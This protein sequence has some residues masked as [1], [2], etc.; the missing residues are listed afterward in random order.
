MRDGSR[1]H[2]VV[3]AEEALSGRHRSWG[4]SA[5]VAVAALVGLGLMLDTIGRSSAT[6]DEPFYLETAARWWRTGDQ[7]EISRAGS[8]LTFWKL[9][10]IPMLWALD[11]L[12]R[13]NWIDDPRRFE[14]ELL[15]MARASSLWIWAAAFAMVAL[16]SRQLY[17]PRAMVLASWWFA[18][19]PNLLAH[20]SLATMETPILA[21]M[22]ATFFLFWIFLRTGDRRVFAG[23]AVAAG[24]AFSCKFTAVLIP[25]I[26]SILWIIAC[27]ID[28][29]QMPRRTIARV[30]AGML[31]FATI[32]AATDLVVTG[33]STVTISPRS[34]DHPSLSG[35]LGPRGEAMVRRLIE[36]P[37]PQDLAAFIRQSVQQKQGAPSYL[38]GEVRS[39]G[40]RYYYLVALAVKV[41]LSFWLILA[42]R[43]WAN[44]RLLRARRDWM[45]P[46]LAVTFVA[47]ASL[48][49]S[50]NFGIRYLLP[51]A[52][53]AI[54]W[55]S[56]L[57]EG[58][59]RLRRLIW[60]GLVLQAIA[61]AT[62]HPHE[63]SYFNVAAGGPI[64]GRRILSD[65]NLDWGQGLRSLGRLQIARPELNDLT[66]YY[67]GDSH[68]SSYGVRG[69]FYE[70]R[71]ID[72]GKLPP[73]LEARTEF[74]AVSASL[75]WGPWA[76]SG[77]FRALAG[78]E[79]FLFTQDTTI[80]V[81]RTADV[82][83]LGG[84][85]AVGRERPIGQASP[86]SRQ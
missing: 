54:I 58:P 12:G 35:R 24:L 71:A 86:G 6:Y 32:M 53:F 17:G 4:P 8:P 67:F 47:M 34:G 77:Y 37:M 20:G 10:Q 9:Q 19:S 22:T 18:L 57:A 80:A 26:L 3:A 5:A 14:P 59:A 27:R 49:S 39:T 42:V 30:A 46:T 15:P 31:V 73:R 40:W 13:G 66:L 84:P 55:I 83:G 36:T 76:P 79:P 21:A 68:P 82:P 33:G 48:G 72:Q 11:H 52:P 63:L 2:E 56:A 50:R 51:V 65:S 81:Y 61:V 41:P 16:W 75:Q 25:P 62:I 1:E 44:R 74:L 28:G 29:E 69:T 38:L 70:V 78:V 85:L 43:F 45:L 60:V 23:S 7:A 64:G